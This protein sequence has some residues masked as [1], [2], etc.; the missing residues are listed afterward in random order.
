[1]V[2]RCGGPSCRVLFQALRLAKVTKGKCRAL[3]RQRPQKH[4]W[5]LHH[6]GDGRNRGVRQGEGVRKGDSEGEVK[7]AG[8]RAVELHFP[9]ARQEGVGKVGDARLLE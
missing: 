6:L 4:P 2:W 5:G 8:Y 7:A 9:E 1:M 3:E